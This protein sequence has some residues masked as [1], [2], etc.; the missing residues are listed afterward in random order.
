MHHTSIFYTK[1][2]TP[3]EVQR[4]QNFVAGSPVTLTPTTTPVTGNVMFAFFGATIDRT[5]T[6][7]AGWTAVPGQSSNAYTN[8]CFY[9]VASSES[10]SYVFTIS[11]SGSTAYNFVEF[12]GLTTTFTTLENNS[13]VSSKFTSAYFT[14][15]N[16]GV[17][18]F[19]VAKNSGSAWVVDGNKWMTVTASGNSKVGYHIYRYPTYDRAV[20]SGGVNEVWQAFGF[21]VDAQLK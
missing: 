4:L 13:G 6:P 15:A 11:P 3:K 9:K 8:Y 17:A 14:P 10:G 20:Y 2:K 7:P 19:N 18:I 12:S 5:I 16:P 1:Y 21:F